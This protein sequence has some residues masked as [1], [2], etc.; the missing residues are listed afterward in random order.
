LA[1]IPHSP[2]KPLLNPV[3]LPPI[4]QGLFCDLCQVE[5]LMQPDDEKIL[6]ITKEIVVKFI[7]LG[8]VSPNNFDERFRS[9][10][11]TLKNTVVDASLPQ[12]EFETLTKRI[13]S[14]DDEDDDGEE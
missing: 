1:G 7:E 2:E 8:R 10:F 12:P 6:R 9:I 4:Q 5:D 11:W 3:G 13:I 14:D